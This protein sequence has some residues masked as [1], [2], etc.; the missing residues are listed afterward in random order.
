MHSTSSFGTPM[1]W[2]KRPQ[3]P[4]VPFVEDEADSLSRELDGSSHVGELPGFEGAKARGTVNQF[5]L[6]EDIEVP[7]V[8]KRCSNVEEKASHGYR[9][10]GFHANQ[11]TTMDAKGP[12]QNPIRRPAGDT[13]GPGKP[14]QRN[15]PTAQDVPMNQPSNP[16]SEPQTSFPGRGQ[17]PTRHP[18]PGPRAPND[19]PAPRPPPRPTPGVVQKSQ[20]APVRST[21][22][23]RGPELRKADLPTR[24]AQPEPGRNAGVR[25]SSPAKHVPDVTERSHSVPSRA[26]SLRRAQ[27]Q[28]KSV[29][30]TRFVQPEPVQ[31]SMRAS[32]PSKRMPDVAQQPQAV[33]SRTTS[34]RRGNDERGPTLTA[35][36]PRSEPI[37]VP[38]VPAGS[39]PPAVPAVV[40]TSQAFP[41]RPAPVPQ[42]I[43][44]KAP[45]IVPHQPVSAREASARGPALPPKQM[46]DTTR[47][48]QPT[49]PRPLPTPPDDE[50]R[51]PRPSSASYKPEM[52]FRDSGVRVEKI[53]PRSSP[54][55]PPTIQRPLS[56]NVQY[57][58]FATS[59]T[60]PPDTPPI[61]TAIPL[62]SFPLRSVPLH[63]L[64]NPPAEGPRSRPSPSMKE[65]ASLK[66][67]P[68]VQ[69]SPNELRSGTSGYVSESAA[70]RQDSVPRPTNRSPPLPIER[71][72]TSSPGS[73]VADRLEEKLKLRREQRELGD[74]LPNL[75]LKS[76]VQQPRISSSSASQSPE[77]KAPPG[78]WPSELHSESSSSSLTEF[79]A[80]EQSPEET[81][82]PAKAAPLKSALRSQSL[83]RGQQSSAKIARRRTV[84]FAENPLEYP[85]K[86]LVKVDHETALTQVPSHED[87]SPNS[88]RSSSPNTGLTLSPC[89][90][91]VPV[92]GYQDWH[93]IEG[94]NHLDICPSCIKQMRKT[95]FRDRLVVSA[96]K[97]RDEPISCAMSEPWTRLAWMQT[98]KKKYETLDLLLEITRPSN[99]QGTKS[100]TGRIINEQYWYRIIDPDTGLYLPQFNICSACVR[101]VRLLMP[102]HRDTFQRS[103]TPQE[104]VCDFVTDSPRFIRYIDALDLASNRAEQDDAPPDLKEFLAY[105]RRKVVLRDCRRSRLIFN[106]WHY[107]PQLPEFTVCEDCY[108][109]IVWPLAKARHPI[110]REFSSVMR[111]LPGDTGSGSREASCQLYSPRIRA[112]FNDA[113]R[114]DDLPFIKWMALTRYDAERQFR[115]RQDELLEDQRR[116][117]ECSMELRKNLEDWKRYE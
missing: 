63:P 98:L 5:P 16:V 45:H 19:L 13:Q 79:P 93:T 74:N 39:L 56:E 54:D 113:V 8:S 108:D 34:A 58:S 37:G 85:S 105:T 114:R 72:S 30:P 101:N 64:P 69:P 61:T 91:S 75:A 29:S 82:P 26:P 42:E 51:K 62:Q 116:G 73:S 59:I 84:A 6:L 70:N 117:Y 32:S 100:C 76:H 1:R 78:A 112:K 77:R 52:V 110:A 9:S 104:R 66:Q 22:L 50:Q 11:T 12:K 27:E 67:T 57:K 109:D 107:M 46:H 68:A 90:R 24:Y 103:P 18:E 21:S 60:P 3:R 106:T 41:P 38:K 48:T 25:T 102:A 49:V 36:T 44:N 71:D 97:H 47:Q 99:T 88:S 40:Q 94:L 10:S 65:S 7:N 95:K 83:D 80:L 17:K 15:Q 87:G 92:A 14:S 4:P 33:P 115:A 96:P 53:L 81:K 31:P 89:P 20:P 28:Q 23:H 55:V 35:I 43:Q 2:R 86:A 111:L